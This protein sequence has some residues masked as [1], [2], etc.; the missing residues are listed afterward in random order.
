MTQNSKPKIIVILGP[1]ASGKS[2]LA[3]H[4][5]KQCNGEVIS[6]DSRQVYKGLDIGSGKITKKEMQGVPHHL[7]DVVSPKQIFSVEDFKIKA[8]E[9]IQTI[10]NK[11]KV[12]IICGGTGF[13]IDTLVKNLVFPEVKPNPAFRTKNLEF[14]AEKLYK[15]LQKLDPKRAKTID[16]QNKVRLIRALEIAISLGKVPK[17]T[18]K[19]LYDPLYIGISW[20][21]DALQKRI[22]KRLLSRLKQGMITEA[23]HL[24]AKGLSFK[25][26]EALGL[27]YR[28]LARYLKKEI[29]KKELITELT[30]KIYQYAKRQI[31]WFKRDTDIHWFTSNELDNVPTI[32]TTFLKSNSEKPSLF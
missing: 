4:I 14:T 1:T 3:V 12:P 28:Y 8:Q 30:L 15:K 5:A 25:R 22:E 6:A 17:I 32:I 23:K 9:A 31:Q 13:Y 20:E 26:M 18:S 19:P 24:H 11:G 2:D 21:K 29:T 10:L 7:L 27:E 16:P